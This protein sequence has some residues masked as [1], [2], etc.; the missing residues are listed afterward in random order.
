MKDKTVN[1]P[2]TLIEITNDQGDK[3]IVDPHGAKIISLILS[4]TLILTSVI[5][6]DGKPGI[7]HPCT[8]IFGPDVNNI[9]GLKQHGGMR[10]EFCM[11]KKI[12]E[13]RITIEHKI[14]D[15][16][17]PKGIKVQQILNIHDGVLSLVSTHWNTGSEQAYVNSAEHFY[18]HSPEGHSGATINGQNILALMGDSTT[19]VVIDWKKENIIYIPG[20]PK[21]ILKQTGFNK[22][23][24]WSGL[25]PTNRKR[26]KD[27]ICI[28]P[29]EYD[30]KDFGKELTIIQPGQKRTASVS[31]S[32]K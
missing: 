2:Q 6:F 13:E 4:N 22:V 5:R 17:Y 15:E 8:P 20:Q 30:P 1:S 10:N 29:V 19:G 28:E 26:D 18:F 11:V 24:L 27:Y 14:Q 21:L 31:I 12:D 9:Y 16:G 32:I 3:L 25:N 7:T 23:V